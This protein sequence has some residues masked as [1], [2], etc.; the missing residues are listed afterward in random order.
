M[1]LRI[2]STGVRINGHTYSHR[3]SC[4]VQSTLTCLIIGHAFIGAYRVK[5]K[6]KNRL[7]AATEEEVA[8]ACGAVPEDGY[9]CPSQI[10]R[11]NCGA[12]VTWVGPVPYIAPHS[13]MVGTSGKPE[14][15]LT[16][17]ADLFPAYSENKPIK[18]GDHGFKPY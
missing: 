18:N 8:F 15:Y 16:G 13:G 10:A 12:I 14:K 5:F 9:M 17:L 3:T 6:H 1:I 7:L 4:E 11:V 2:A